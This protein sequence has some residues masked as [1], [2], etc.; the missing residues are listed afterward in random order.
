MEKSN[1]LFANIFTRADSDSVWAG[2]SS[3]LLLLNVNLKR[4]GTIVRWRWTL[5]TPLVSD[6]LIH[7]LPFFCFIQFL[8]VRNNE[9]R[10]RKPDVSSSSSRPCHFPNQSQ[11]CSGGRGSLVWLQASSE[12]TQTSVGSVLGCSCRFWSEAG[13]SL[14][15]WGAFHLNIPPPPPLCTAVT[16][17]L[18]TQEVP[19][20]PVVG[21]V[22]SYA[23]T[24][25]RWLRNDDDEFLDNRRVIV[26]T[27]LLS[28]SSAPAV[29]LFF[30]T[31]LIACWTQT[32]VLNTAPEPQGGQRDSTLGPRPDQ[33]N[34]D[35]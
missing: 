23:A 14:N 21:C 5:Q 6:P 19:A 13:C 1:F 26:H 27:V 4:I 7:R 24:G 33:T 25:R 17:G 2:Y 29:P 28:Q 16:W 12:I 20:R 22:W 34:T 30:A 18:I 15:R 10:K 3:L 8:G 32:S 31:F 11:R 9:N 35:V